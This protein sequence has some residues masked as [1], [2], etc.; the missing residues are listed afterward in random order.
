MDAELGGEQAD[1]VGLVGLGRS[2]GDVLRPGHDGVLRHDVDDVAADVLLD[3]LAGGAAADEERAAGEHGVETVPIV[4]RRLD[5][6]RGGCEPGVV[7]DDVDAA[8]AV[9]R[10]GEHRRHLVLGGD[11]GGDAERPL[12][13]EGGGDLLGPLAVE[14]GDDHAR[15]VAG[16]QLGD[17]PAD[18][19]RRTGDEGDAALQRRRRRAH[20]QLALLELPV[21]DAELLVVVD[22]RV[23]RHRLGAA[24]HVDRVDVEL[25]GDACRLRVGAEAPHAD[26]GHEDDHR[27]GAA[28]RRRA[29]LGVGVVVGAG[30]RRGTARAARSRRVTLLVER[31]RRRQVEVQ[32]PHLGAQEVVGARRALGGQARRR[33]AGRGSRARRV[34]R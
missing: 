8:E 26:A 14:V 10:G 22:R 17:G 6:R 11:V 27:I 24:H 5:E 1:L 9:G 30:S 21:L 16:E 31:R 15:P 12:G 25:A 32:R 18:P 33:L 34:R 20:A 23:R 7:D 13:A 29:L 4:D 2:V 3:H 28:H 19:R